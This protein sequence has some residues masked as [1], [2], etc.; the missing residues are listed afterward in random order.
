MSASAPVLGSISPRL[1]TPARGLLTKR[2][3]LG[4]DALRFWRDELKFQPMPHQRW[5]ILN[6]EALNPDSTPTFRSGLVTMAR[7][8]GKTQFSVAYSL[9][10]LS[11]GRS[12]LFSSASLATARE[13][14]QQVCDGA[15]DMGW[16][17]KARGANS[18]ESVTVGRASFSVLSNNR[19]A[20]RGR[21]AQVIIVDELRAHE[22][23]DSLSAIESCTSTYPDAKLLYFSNAGDRRAV[24]L[25]RYRALGLSGEEPSF[26]LAEWS[27][28]PE[29]PIDSVEDWRMANPALGRTIQVGTLRAAMGTKPPAVFRVEELNSGVT[30]L[31][32]AITGAAWAA[33]LDP[34]TLDGFRDRI[35]LGFDVSTDSDHATLVAAAVLPDGKV[36]VETVA[37]WDS[38]HEARTDLPGLI[39]QIQP[40][41]VGWVPGG[42]VNAMAPTLKAIRTQVELTGGE[43]T[44]MCVD[45]AARID[46]GRLLHSGDDLLGSQITTSAKYRVGDSWRF[47]RAGSQTDASYA[48]AAAVRLA[49][50]GDDPEIGLFFV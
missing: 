39:D 11:R 47:D 24:P 7:R 44:G 17:F 8:N 22:N 49:A 21:G 15:D 31:K 9:W 14:W 43:V 41:G 33:C 27:S 30:D 3:T 6:L 35:A 48:M 25:A 18:Q 1:H 13:T 20:A 40:I 19:N 45:L 38:L 34:G 5:L 50:N 2:S 37:A 26:F 28:R 23:F 16:K 12:V 29:C 32:A 4:Y 46:S 10:C 36:R 42:A